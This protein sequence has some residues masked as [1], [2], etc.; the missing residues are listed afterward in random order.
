MKLVKSIILFTTIFSFFIYPASRAN[1]KQAQCT[2]QLR[3]MKYTSRSSAEAI[4]WQKEVRAKLF[5]LLKIDDL[6]ARKKPIPFQPEQLYSENKGKFIV[7]EL[8]IN[9]TPTRRIHIV[10]TIPTLQKVPFPAVVCIGGHGS[11]RYSVYDQATIKRK[12]LEWDKIYKGFAS[13]LAAKGVVTISTQVSQ[14]DI[15]EGDKGRMLMGERLWDVMRCVDYLESMPEV[16]RSRIGCGGFS[17]GAEMST[18]LG[19]MDE[20]IAAVV[21]AVFLTTMDQMEQNHCMCWKFDGLRELIDFAD[22]FSLIAPRPLQCQNGL[23]EGPTQFYVP[24]ARKVMEEVRTIYVDFDRPENAVLDVH[25]GGHEIDLPALMY[26][27]QKHLC[28]G[29][30]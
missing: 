28:F 27:F 10:L 13:A 22:L 26:F 15:Y 12:V 8:L 29:D 14:H 23:K 2:S 3:T 9:S 18:W 4:A 7:K 20:R 24:L 5:R 17:L 11:N 16:D 21:S 6:A 25:K 19:A 1:A 30:E